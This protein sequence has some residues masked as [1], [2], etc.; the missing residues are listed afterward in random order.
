MWYDIKHHGIAEIEK[1]VAEYNIWEDSYKGIP[2]K[3]GGGFKGNC[4]IE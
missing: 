3:E 2:F 1:V 4:I